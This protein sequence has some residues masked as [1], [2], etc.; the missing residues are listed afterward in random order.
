MN[1]ASLHPDKQRQ[2]VRFKGKIVVVTGASAGVGRAVARAFASAGA[3]VALIAREPDA[4]EEARQEIERGGTR[5]IAVPADMANPDAVFAAA[6]RIEEELGAIDI[7]I[8]DAMTTVFSR[9][10]DMEPEEFRRVTEVTYLGFVYGT[11]AALSH[12]KKR[13]R[14]LIVQVGSALGYR[15]IPLQA[16]Y[17]GAKSA[18]RGFTEALR[19]E[20]LHDGGKIRVTMVQL[21]AVN[22]PQFD[23]ARVHVDHYPRPVA[24]VFQPEAI[25]A[26]VLDAATG[27]APEYWLGL[28]TVKAI[29]AS[30]AFPAVVDRYLARKGIDSQQTKTEISGDRR[31]NLF[32]AVH[33]LHRTRGSFGSKARSSVAMWS[34]NDVRVAAIGTLAALSAVA[35]A[36]ILLRSRTRNRYH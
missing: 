15:G 36:G 8:N 31:N 16:A 12:M 34:G 25:A 14:G 6:A 29:L 17:C 19:T 24:P 26:A 32:Q 1:I 35:A 30:M 3:S 20:L 21:P 5:V 28:S 18:I 22:T 4:L 27:S 33:G 11:M 2:S 13:D 9:V 7:W 23:W 10:T